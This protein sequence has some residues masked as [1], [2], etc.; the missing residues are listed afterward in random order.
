MATAFD[1]ALVRRTDKTWVRQSGLPLCDVCGVRDSCRLRSAL[2][3]LGQVQRARVMIP[4]CGTYVPVIGFT[5]PTG[6][7]GEFNTFR[8]GLGWA[9]RLVIGQRVGLYDLK[10]DRMVGY[11]RVEAIVSGVLGDLLLSHSA[12][13]HLM[14][15]LPVDDAPEALQRVLRKAYGTTYAAP[16]ETF[17]VIECR[18]EP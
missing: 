1:Q 9:R 3:T 10:A 11:A 17:S 5:D 18:R 4:E 6:T 13:N 12:F 7:D 15:A 8:R 14:K 2:A 16:S